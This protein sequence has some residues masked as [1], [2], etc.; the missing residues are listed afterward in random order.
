L[1]RRNFRQNRSGQVIVVTALLVAI[2]LLSTAVYVVK[3]EKSVPSAAYQADVYPAYEE[4]IRNTLISALA[5]V[6]GGG[7]PA[8][9]TTDL[10]QLQSALLAHS[11]QDI[12]QL[13]YTPLDA[14]P[15]QDGFWVSSGTNG[16]GVSSVCVDFAFSSTSLSQT[17]SMAY[18]ANVTSQIAVT[19]SYQQVSDSQK[20]ITLT[21]SVLNEGSPALAQN[22]LLQ[23]QVGTDWVAVGSPIINDHGDGTYSISFNAETGQIGDPVVVSVLCEDQRGIFVGASLTCNTQ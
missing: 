2:V 8:V 7:N 19:G 17:S 10:S 22:F 16:H 3:T 21:I 14:T 9:L 12:L 4:N 13:D 5:N 18:T 23:Y 11:Y 20:E 6:T 1:R 15:Y